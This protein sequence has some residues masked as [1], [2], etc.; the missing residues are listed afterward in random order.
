MAMSKQSGFG[1][2]LR[3]K[4]GIDGVYWIVVRGR[5]IYDYVGCVVGEKSSSRILSSYSIGFMGV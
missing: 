3:G 2:F 4:F 5:L 1:I